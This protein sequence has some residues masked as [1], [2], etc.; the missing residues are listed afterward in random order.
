MSAPVLLTTVDATGQAV[1]A[2][3]SSATDVTTW[4]YTR[5]K[6]I[7][8]LAENPSSSPANLHYFLVGG[9]GSQGQGVLASANSTNGTTTSAFVG[10]TYGG[11]HQ[12]GNWT[13]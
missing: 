13:E 11:V 3:Q 7:H 2:V 10:T 5:A 9:P 8:D 12:L 6:V 4:G 1:L